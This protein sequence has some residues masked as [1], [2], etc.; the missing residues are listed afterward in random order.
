MKDSKNIIYGLTDPSD[1]Q[2]RYVGKS[3]NGLLRPKAHARLSQSKGSTYKDRWVRK[4]RRLG[5]NYGI[6]VL[7]RG[8]PT[9]DL[10][11]AEQRWIR[12]YREIGARLTNLTDGGPGNIG[13][14]PSPATRKKISRANQGRKHDDEFRQ[15]VSERMKGNTYALGSTASAET[16]RKMSES[17]KGQK[18]SAEF[19]RKLSKRM[20]G[21]TNMRGKTQSAEAREKIGAANRGRIKSEET[22]QRIREALSRPETKEKLSAWQCG[23]TISA[24]QRKK[25]SATLTGRKASPETRA[26][27]SKSQTGRTASAETRKKLSAA[28]KGKKRS[29]ET[30]ERMRLAA[31]NPSAETRAKMSSSTKKS[32]SKEVRQRLR[33]ANLGKKLSPETKKKLSEAGRGRVHS[34]ETRKKLSESKKGNTNYRFRVFSE[35]SLK[36]MSDAAYER[37][38]NGEHP[39]KGLKRSE[40]TKAKIGLANSKRIWT[41]ESKAKQSESQR[42]R[43]LRKKQGEVTDGPA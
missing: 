7:E 26:K 43:W 37:F 20:K 38:K 12:H 33:E 40:A 17:Q 10:Y 36:K 23:K 2:V 1:G 42:R 25:I 34:L 8:I 31:T 39:A 27:M 4:L 41:E 9:E 19:S 21:N 24:E 30:I 22:K 35:E 29:P 5:L 14:V 28:L 6:V 13:W 32:M 3:M 11:D 15:Q 18:R 16:R